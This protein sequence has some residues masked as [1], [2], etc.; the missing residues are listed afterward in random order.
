[1]EGSMTGKRIWVIEDKTPLMKYIKDEAR[2]IESVLN[3][4]L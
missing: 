4:Y 2:I 1:M 3:S